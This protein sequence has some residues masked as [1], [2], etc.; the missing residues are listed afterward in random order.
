MILSSEDEEEE[1]GLLTS[2]PQ[3]IFEDSTPAALVSQP[4]F[5]AIAED[6]IEVLVEE[7][8][9]YFF[10]PLTNLTSSPVSK[11]LQVVHEH[12]DGIFPTNLIT[13]S[14]L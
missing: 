14:Q 9:K 6:D 11:H 7:L 8:E 12:L 2:K 4:A 10:S 3:P 5:I 1:T 13:S